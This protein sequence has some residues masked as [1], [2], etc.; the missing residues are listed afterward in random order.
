M[1]KITTQELVFELKLL[2]IDNYMIPYNNSRVI[3]QESM[4]LFGC[5][6]SDSDLLAAINI[7]RRYDNLH[8]TI[9]MYFS[10]IIILNKVNKESLLP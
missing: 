9:S 1:K 3:V 4:I 2:G 10:G 7:C 5:D 8:L 6:I